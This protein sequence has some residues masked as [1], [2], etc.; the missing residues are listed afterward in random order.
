MVII[1]VFSGLVIGGVIFAALKNTGK[2]ASQSK[3][4]KLD[5]G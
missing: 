1:A 2:S 5:I 3:Y 4:T